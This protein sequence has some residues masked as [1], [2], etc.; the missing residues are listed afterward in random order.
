MS[1]AQNQ[2]TMACTIPPGLIEELKSLFTGKDQ[3]ITPEN[4]RYD[5]ALQRWSDL[6]SQRAVRVKLSF[7]SQSALLMLN[8]TNLIGCD[9][10]S[11]KRRKCFKGCSLCPGEQH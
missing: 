6:A 4:P 7:D 3:V 11:R 9:R 8:W 1:I 2:A 5:E 10:L